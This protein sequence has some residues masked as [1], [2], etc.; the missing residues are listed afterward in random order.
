MRRDF[1]FGSTFATVLMTIQAAKLV[2]TVLH[3]KHLQ[4]LN[5]EPLN[6]LFDYVCHKSTFVFIP[7]V[8]HVDN[9]A[10]IAQ[11]CLTYFTV[12]NN[13]VSVHALVTFH[14]E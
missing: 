1:S 4:I 9:I 2:C 7:P 5:L 12:I 3:I 11:H 13:G 6:V 10:L 8:S 14:G